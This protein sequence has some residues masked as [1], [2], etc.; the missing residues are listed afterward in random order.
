MMITKVFPKKLPSRIKE[1]VQTLEILC[2]FN[3]TSKHVQFCCPSIVSLPVTEI[4]LMFSNDMIS[5]FAFQ[6]RTVG[7]SVLD[8][9]QR[10]EYI[11]PHNSIENEFQFHRFNVISQRFN[12]KAIVM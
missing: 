4:V 6:S 8:Q 3:S 7:A 9:K 5:S 2:A 12:L 11:L 10:V 1:N